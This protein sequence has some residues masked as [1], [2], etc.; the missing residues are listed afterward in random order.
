MQPMLN[1]RRHVPISTC[2]NA[3][4]VFRVGPLG[5]RYPVL[6][7]H[8]SSTSNGAIPSGCRLPL[9]VGTG[10]GHTLTFHQGGSITPTKALFGFQA[11][12]GGRCIDPE[13]D[14]MPKC[15]MQMQ[16]LSWVFAVS[17]IRPIL[18]GFPAPLPFVHQF[19][20]RGRSYTQHTFSR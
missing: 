13:Q 3:L 15:R 19:L 8:S 18:P 6:H 16:G 10:S 5:A 2:T 20:S 12:A 9:S 11:C 4:S 17:S 7:A 1:T 14:V